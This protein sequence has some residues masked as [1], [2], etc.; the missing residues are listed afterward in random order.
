[1]T[2]ASAV[3]LLLLSASTALAAEKT[4]EPDNAHTVIGFRAAT[5]LFDVPGR[6]EKSTVTLSGDP[7]APAGAKVRV[8]I[9]AASVTTGIDQRDDH[10]RAADFFDVQKFP[11]IVFEANKVEKQGNKVT[12]TGTLE[13]HGVKQPVTLPL[14]V[15]TAKNGAGYEETVYKGQTTV[16]NSAFG[17]GAQSVAA[18]ISLKDDVVLDIILAGFWNDPPAPAA[19]PAPAKKDDKPAKKK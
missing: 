3:A 12:V 11:K 18:K 19:A 15:V 8:E 2:R 5:V 17:I 6:F 10:L 9:D 14:E 16:K 4:W 13:M 7:E 1:M